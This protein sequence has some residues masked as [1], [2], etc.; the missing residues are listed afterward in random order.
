MEKSELKVLKEQLEAKG[1]TWEE[2]AGKIK[3]E[4]SLLN[5]Y[6]VSPP[7]PISVTNPLKKLLEA[8]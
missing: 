1:I 7:V 4:V 6:L 2:A 3:F 8:A 5:L